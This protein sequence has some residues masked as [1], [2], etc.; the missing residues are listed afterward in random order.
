MMSFFGGLHPGHGSNPSHGSDDA[1]SETARP[2]R[3]ASAS[4][5]GPDG[6][7]SKMEVNCNGFMHRRLDL[8]DKGAARGAGSSV[9]MASHPTRH[10]RARGGLGGS[11]CV[12]TRS[13]HCKVP[14]SGGSNFKSE[15]LDR[16]K[17]LPS[18]NLQEVNQTGN[19]A[20]EA[21]ARAGKPGKAGPPLLRWGLWRARLAPR[22]GW[23]P[24]LSAP[25]PATLLLRVLLTH[26][27][28]SHSW[29]KPGPAFFTFSL[30]HVGVM[31]AE[32]RVLFRHVFLVR[33][34]LRTRRNGPAS[35]LRAPALAAPPEAA[36]GAAA[37]QVGAR[38]APAPPWGV[39]MASPRSPGGEERR[40]PRRET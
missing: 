28:L 19:P 33:R 11:L 38:E 10:P 31:N 14:S 32:S 26:G 12:A 40:F 39:G 27:A 1:A 37:R 7:F 25:F 9:W 3:C 15:G 17:T 29:G 21:I 8:S 18:D 23:R 24:R 36:A 22:P 13:P 35:R 6:F 4:S 30:T 2:S 20:K 34:L 16:G 5:S